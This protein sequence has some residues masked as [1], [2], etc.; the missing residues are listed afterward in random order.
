MT[1]R[2]S[3][4]ALSTVGRAMVAALK[5]RMRPLTTFV[6]GVMRQADHRI[7]AWLSAVRPFPARA[8]NPQC[9]HFFVG[10]LGLGGT[11]RSIANLVQALAARG[12]TCKVW[13]LDD[14]DGHFSEEVL[15]AG[16][17]VEGIFSGSD[18]VRWVASYIS[19][20]VGPPMLG[21]PAIALARGLSR[22]PPGVLQCYLDPTNVIGALG[23][24][25]AGVPVVAL[26]LQSLH[27]R[28]CTW[29]HEYPWT[30]VYDSLVPECGDVLIAN[31]EA[32]RRSF[33]EQEPAFPKSKIRMV[34]NIVRAHPS[35]SDPAQRRP[36]SPPVILWLARVAP[37]KRPDLF[38]ACLERLRRVGVLF[39]A[40]VA[41]SGNSLP[42]MRR[43]VEAS[44]LGRSVRFLGAVSSVE[45]LLD[46]ASV[47]VL[48]S[49]S[50]GSPNSIQEA[51]AAGCPVIATAVG[52]SRELIEDGVTGFLVPA[53]DVSL[54]VA[55]VIRVLD[56]QE[57]AG[58]IATAARASVAQRFSAEQVIEDTLSI[59]STVRS[60]KG[61]VR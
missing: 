42:E 31:S 37:E 54:L 14:Q 61:R 2:R 41:G 23:G 56:D 13:V 59:Y 38:V 6:R 25:L 9:I 27:P 47:M 46:A 35:Q 53:G 57:L 36:L 28:Q 55:R 48:C 5:A 52:G 15:R 26:G 19:R 21:C 18:P 20:F 17:V 33:A 4:L 8:P 12:F 22:D 50:E 60:E 7:Y 24:R 45:G 51:Q 34:G 10:T 30:N 40:W 16:A 11:Q 39:Q 49:D 32:G 58:R 43:L 44:G 1:N 3:L 29:P